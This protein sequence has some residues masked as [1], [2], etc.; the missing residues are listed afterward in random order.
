MTTKITISGLLLTWPR[1][2]SG[3]EN[4]DAMIPS[5]KRTTMSGRSEDGPTTRGKRSSFHHD[6][7]HWAAQTEES[8]GSGKRSKSLESSGM[9]GGSTFP[10]VMRF[11]PS[12]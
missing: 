7:P 3:S 5:V 11:Q 9:R 10:P 6:F 2:R 8:Y 4:G 1:S 12:I